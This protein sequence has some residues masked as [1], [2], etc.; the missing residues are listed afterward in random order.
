MSE[1][2]GHAGATA[3]ARE[4][5][6]VAGTVVRMLGLDLPGAALGGDEFA[7]AGTSD[8]ARAGRLH[9]RRLSAPAASVP[10]ARPTTART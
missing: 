6:W 7:T 9:G 10:T 3:P 2:P 5:A 4:A 1:S 8:L